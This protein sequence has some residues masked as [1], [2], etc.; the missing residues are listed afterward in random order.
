MFEVC[1]FCGVIEENALLAPNDECR[2]ELV[3]GDIAARTDGSQVADPLS[4]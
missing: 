2:V 3:I 1:V 4:L